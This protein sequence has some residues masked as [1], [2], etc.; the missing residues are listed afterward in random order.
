MAP[1]T[2]HLLY[3]GL[4]T[5]GEAKDQVRGVSHPMKKA[6]EAKL[7]AMKQKYPQPMSVDSSRSHSPKLLVRDAGNDPQKS[8]CR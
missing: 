8:L 1:R 6:N 7:K 2:H 3:T 5:L 4:G